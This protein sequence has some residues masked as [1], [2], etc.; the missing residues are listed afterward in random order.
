MTS[1]FRHAGPAEL[2]TALRD[3]HDRTLALFECLAAAGFDHASRVPRLDIVNPPLWELG[4]IA[5]FAEWY[6]LRE[7][8]SSDP[9]SVRHPSLLPDADAWFDSNTVRHDTRWSLALPSTAQVKNYFFEVHERITARL[10]QTAQNGSQSDEALYP[11]RLILSH[12]DMHIE[13]FFYTLN[14]LEIALPAALSCNA[15]RCERAPALHFDGAILERGAEPGKGFSFDNERWRHACRVD[16]FEIDATPVSNADFYAFI[17]GGGYLK[18]EHWSEEGRTWLEHTGRTAPAGWEH[19]DG[20]RRCRRFGKMHQLNED[21]PVR[22]V[23][24]FEAQA[25]CAWAG[26]RLPD[27]LEWERAARSGHPDFQWGQVW[28]WT[29][30]R[31]QPYP[32]FSPGAYREYSAPY[33]GDHQSVRGASFATSD[34]LRSAHFRNY[35]QAHRDDIFV[36]FRTCAPR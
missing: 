19:G 33:F 26:R 24:L 28:E 12:E 31:F 16:A 22:H 35:Y 7:A 14:T 6:T 32:G 9:R 25:Y 36:G 29:A 3:A 15:G 18:L 4:H 20:K 23:T 1:S 17:D 30:S 13:A 2:I 21:E 10:A 34:R 8:A 27:E 5:W 11:Y